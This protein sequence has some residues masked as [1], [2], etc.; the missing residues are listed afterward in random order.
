MS[1]NKNGGATMLNLAEV[2]AGDVL[3]CNC[4]AD[5]DAIQIQI[6]NWTGSSYVHAAICLGR[7]LASLSV[8]VCNGFRSRNSSLARSCSGISKRV[9]LG[10]KAGSEAPEIS[11][12]VRS[13]AAPNTI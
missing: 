1:T 12:T 2:R 7:T 6:Q 11:L 5:C 13:H 3:L 4:G 8:P 10:Y 9:W